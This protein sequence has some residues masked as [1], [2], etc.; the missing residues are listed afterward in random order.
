MSLQH[1]R[2]K[3]TRARTRENSRTTLWIRAERVPCSLMLF[4]LSDQ[5]YVKLP[6]YVL[7]NAAKDKSD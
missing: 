6:S 4:G 2:W 3:S 5:E 1:K 7:D